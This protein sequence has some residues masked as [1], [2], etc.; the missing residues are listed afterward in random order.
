[1]AAAMNRS[2][3][4]KSSLLRI[5]A[6]LALLLGA[7]FFTVRQA[8]TLLARALQVAFADQQS[9][10]ASVWFE[11]DGDVV[12]KQLVLRPNDLGAAAETRFERVHLATPGWGWF[13]RNSL[14]RSLANARLDQIRLVLSEGSSVAGLDPLLVDLGPIGAVTASPFEAE[15][16]AKNTVWTREE[17][18]EMGL[19]PG[20][21]TLDLNYRLEGDVF[22]S[23]IALET[24]GISRTQ[25]DR[26]SRI[27]APVA[28][29]L[30]GQPAS[31]IESE[32]WQVR[33]HGF[34][35]AR[36]R[37]CAER[38]NI[39]TRRFVERHLAA[40]DRR[41]ETLGL[42]A[43]VNARALYRRFAR[44]GGDLAFGGDYTPPLTREQLMDA[45]DDGRALL[46][47]NAMLERDGR[48]VPVL[49]QEVAPRP[50][51]A[52][53]Q[54]VATYAAMQ[55]EL[56]NAVRGGDEPVPPA[57]ALPE[58][59][60]VTAAAEPEKI[61]A[62]APSPPV[63][64]VVPEPPA[65]TAS[66]PVAEPPPT[67]VATPP[68]PVVATPETPVVTPVPTAEPPPP[69]VVPTRKPAVSSARP[70]RP[71]IERLVEEAPSQ[72][73]LS[74]DA[75][76]RHR[77]KRIRIWTVHNP[78]RNVELLDASGDVLR[79]RVKLSGGEAEYTVQR[80]GFLRAKLLR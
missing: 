33:D 17:L 9:S 79:V 12:A 25:L 10:F 20:A 21:T 60:P 19:A 65:E 6:V 18:T 11:W 8:D 4:S 16:C 7:V 68:E 39:D 56:E 46:R 15:G 34:V 62:P 22:A 74:W 49:W 69:T 54:G 51:P 76:A 48:G 77:G 78:P 42:A 23:S 28:S 71:R 5:I 41:L 75:L 40:V 52:V 31:N 44:G 61:D 14:D 36:N 47:L 38:D 35:L 13:L 50:L 43:D 57:A 30:A 53:D 26:S 66:E 55:T 70:N 2:A 45:R 59:T 80:A 32:R 58:Q 29:L 27:T 63:A 1:M 3:P 24:L 64:V 73:T 72:D 67:P 37:F